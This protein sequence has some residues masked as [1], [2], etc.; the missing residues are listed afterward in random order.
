MLTRGIYD[1]EANNTNQVLVKDKDQSLE[2]EQCSQPTGR[3]DKK[4]KDNKVHP[5]GLGDAVF[6][7]ELAA[8]NYMVI[9]D[10][11]EP[12]QLTCHFCK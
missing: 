5:N 3:K 12:V 7:N 11:T 4:N 6:E 2:S 10:N 8:K 1:T 9:G